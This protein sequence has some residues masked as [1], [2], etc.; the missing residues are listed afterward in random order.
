MFLVW[1]KVSAK[2]LD[3]LEISAKDLDVLVQYKLIS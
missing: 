3:L 1:L 2:N